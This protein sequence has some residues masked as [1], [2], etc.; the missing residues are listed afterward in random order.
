MTTDSPC[1]QQLHYTTSDGEVEGLVKY[2]IAPRYCIAAE[3]I[4]VW[5][6]P[7]YG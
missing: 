6:E 7:D 1:Q 4:Q 5:M 3:D 2:F